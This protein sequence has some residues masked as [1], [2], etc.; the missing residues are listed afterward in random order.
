MF[1]SMLRR[2]SLTLVIYGLIIGVGF[3]FAF[4][5]LALT[6]LQSTLTNNSPKSSEEFT[7]RT[8]QSLM[9]S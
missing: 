6:Y 1:S 5:M 7:V 8:S 2:S 4:V 9:G 3:F